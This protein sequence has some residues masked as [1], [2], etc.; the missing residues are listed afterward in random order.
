MH[1]H[2]GRRDSWTAGRGSTA[3]APF[4]ADEAARY[5]AEWAEHLGVD[6]ETTN[7]IGITFRLIPPGEFLKGSTEDEAE[8]HVVEIAPLGASFRQFT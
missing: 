8:A 7:S 6:V 2:L 1:D 3:V 4:D 5:Q